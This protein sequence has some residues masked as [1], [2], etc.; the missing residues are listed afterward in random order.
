MW[1]QGHLHFIPLQ[2]QRESGLRLCH[3]TSWL[4]LQWGHLKHADLSCDWYLGAH[5]WIVYHL[6]TVLFFHVISFHYKQLEELDIKVPEC[7]FWVTCVH[8]NSLKLEN[9]FHC[10]DQTDSVVKCLN[11]MIQ[12][13]L[14]SQW[15]F[16]L[17]KKVSK[18]K[19][20]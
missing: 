16:D 19:D 5:T 2:Q 15:V 17:R 9:Y 6:S 3:K 8:L 11:T 18:L 12:G 1:V 4:S 7:F 13:A 20:T 10:L 14:F